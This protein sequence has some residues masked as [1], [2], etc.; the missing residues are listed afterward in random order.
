MHIKFF[1]PSVLLLVLGQYFLMLKRKSLK[2][3]TGI[4]TFSSVDFQRGHHLYHLQSLGKVGLVVWKG[5]RFDCLRTDGLLS[6]TK[7]KFERNCYTI[8]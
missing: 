6:G 4:K 8:T 5:R 3:K 2:E 7:L 1:N